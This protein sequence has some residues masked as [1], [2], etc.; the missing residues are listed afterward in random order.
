M[1]NESVKGESILDHDV[2]RKMLWIFGLGS[3]MAMLYYEY[4]WSRFALGSLAMVSLGGWISASLA[5]TAP[6]SFCIACVSELRQAAR[7][8][9]CDRDICLK[10]SVLVELAA[11]SAYWILA[12]EIHRLT[13]LGV[14]R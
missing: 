14:L 2:W 7:K 4:R 3:S 12:P 9:K 1:S 13:S 11:L 10:I 5:I 8:G 6:W